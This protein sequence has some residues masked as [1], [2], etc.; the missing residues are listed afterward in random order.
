MKKILL[1]IGF[2]IISALLLLADGGR[3]PEISEENW[4]EIDQLSKRADSLMARKLYEDAI[5]TYLKVLVLNPRD[6]T[7]HN[8][9]GIA[10]HMLLDLRKAKAEY[11]QAKKLNPK[12]Y[13]AWNN[14]GTV[15][16]SL[17][18]YKKAIKYYRK[19]VALNST[20]ATTYHNLGAAY[21]AVK[22]YDE[23][24]QSFQEAFRLDPAILE[25]ISSSGTIIRTADVNQ[26][27]QNFYIAKLYI[28]SGQSEKALSYLLKALENGFDDYDKITQDPDFK[29][30]A[31]DERLAR[32]L[33]SKPSPN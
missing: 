12:Y 18:N 8:K 10:Y 29:A 19:A 17:K 24:F 11:E 27:V 16:Y 1:I 31:Q 20:S 5:L 15:Y 14:L 21:F 13:E 33:P 4:A 6:P 2:V 23:G 30:L 7:A 26:G 28:Q 9:L 25:R 22:K 32:M 3:R